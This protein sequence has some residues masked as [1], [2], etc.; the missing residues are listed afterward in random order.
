MKMQ[1]SASTQLPFLYHAG[2]S[3]IPFTLCQKIF[4]SYMLAINTQEDKW[5][6]A[7]S[8]AILLHCL[9]S[10]GHHLFYTLPEQGATL[11]KVMAALERHVVREAS[12]LTFRQ[13]VQRVHEIASHAVCLQVCSFNGTMLF[14]TGEGGTSERSANCTCSSQCWS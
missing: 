12:V 13:C 10:E 3:P 14:L 7:S 4:N 6:D 11:N 8:H 1:A 9:G 2:E 5:P